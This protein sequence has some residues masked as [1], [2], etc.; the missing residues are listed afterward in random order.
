MMI[1]STPVPKTKYSWKSASDSASGIM[2]GD[3]FSYAQN[4]YIPVLFPCYR[5]AF[6]QVWNFLYNINGSEPIHK[7]AVKPLHCT[8]IHRVVRSIL[9]GTLLL[10]AGPPQTLQY[11]IG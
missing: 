11:R 2:I 8:V 10:Y 3:F 4:L 1:I 7:N 6:G 9:Q 5:S